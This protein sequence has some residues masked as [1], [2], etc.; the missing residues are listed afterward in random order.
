MKS[1]MSLK[2]SLLVI[3]DLGDVVLRLGMLHVVF[4][5]VL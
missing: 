5:D 1:G 4:E 3:V 2:E